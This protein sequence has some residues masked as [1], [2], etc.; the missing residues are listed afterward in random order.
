MEAFI[1]SFY[2]IIIFLCLLSSVYASL[3][4]NGRPEYCNRRYSEITQI[5]AHNSFFVGDGFSDN[6][7]LTV[8]EQLKAGI[9]FS[10]CQTQRSFWHADK[11]EMCHTNCVLLDAGPLEN[12][13]S[14]IKAWF[15][16]NPHEVLTLLLTNGG[17]V[18]IK[19]FG[20]AFSTSGLDSYAYSPVP[21]KTLAMNEWPTLEQLINLD[22]RL[23]VFLDYGADTSI[24]PYILPEWDY[25]FETPFSQT[26]AS[27]L[28]KCEWDRPYS[29][30]NPERM[31]LLNH[32]LDKKG[33][34]GIPFPNSVE[35]NGKI[36]APESIDAQANVCHSKWGR[37]PN[38]ILVD[39]FD[40]GD[41]FKAQDK[42]NNIKEA[43]S[44]LDLYRD[45][46]E[47]EGEE[48]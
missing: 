16:K 46:D 28:S 2:R 26:D 27:T 3:A 48:D 8:T 18:G 45:E 34:F 44:E 43:K 24:V 5:G 37:M 14:E 15:E 41:V 19:H 40:V 39:N 33:I 4:C 17:N 10:Q 1:S 36:N 42:L 32:I 22:Q 25:F 12:Y 47:D 7:R 11:V 20:E 6:Q 29:G 9:R 23:I 13:L 30:G 21:G 38:V 35:E 31:Y